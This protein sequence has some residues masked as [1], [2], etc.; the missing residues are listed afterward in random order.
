MSFGEELRRERELREISLR[1]VAEATKIN[2]RYL[3]AL[4]RNEFEHLPGGVFNKG[5]VRAYA[6]FIGV[7]PEAMV[8]A[9]LLEQ[10]QDL[11]D[12]DPLLRGS[13]LTGG[14]A[15]AAPAPTARHRWVVWLVVALVILA[16]GVFLLVRLLRDDHVAQRTTPGNALP[17]AV[18]SDPVPEGVRPA[19]D[20]PSRDPAPA[21]ETTPPPVAPDRP[22]APDEGGATSLLVLR[23]TSGRV[24][25]DNR[26]IE[27]LDG[28]PVGTT[29]TLRCERFL[30]ID[31]A[32]GGALRVDGAAPAGD[33]V[34]LRGHRVDIGRVRDADGGESP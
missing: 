30:L 20:R 17:A 14:R 9:Y 25:C 2:L 13:R 21:D 22:L 5:F 7:D 28:L 18:A 6:Q 26:R 8:N 19:I 32:D 29:I 27:M 23:A 31:A 12:N 15:S 24:N 10:S 34:A 11:D 4:E 33:G 16:V 3:E 1:E